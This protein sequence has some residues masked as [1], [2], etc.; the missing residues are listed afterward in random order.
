MHRLKDIVAVIQR[1]KN[2]LLF[3]LQSK[4]IFRF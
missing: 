1:D 2:I 3:L 4:R